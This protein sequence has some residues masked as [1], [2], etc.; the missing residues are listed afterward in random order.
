MS[1]TR[2]KLIFIKLGGTVVVHDDGDS[3]YFSLDTTEEGRVPRVW[4]D[5]Y[6]VQFEGRHVEITIEDPNA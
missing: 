3:I 5:D 6:L 2:G 4:I 1:D